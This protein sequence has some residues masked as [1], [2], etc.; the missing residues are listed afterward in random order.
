[1]VQ[2]APEQAS[3]AERLALVLGLAFKRVNVGASE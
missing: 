1:M 3:G 2:Q